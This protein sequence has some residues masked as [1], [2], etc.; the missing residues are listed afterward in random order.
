MTSL[1]TELPDELYW[2]TEKVETLVRPAAFPVKQDSLAQPGDTRYWGQPDWPADKGE[3]IRE[4][5]FFQLNL[6]T[7]PDEAR[8]PEWPVTGLVWVFMD[9]MDE[10]FRPTV[11]F[12]ARP[13]ASIPW[14]PQAAQAGC[15]YIIKDTVPEATPKTLPE[16]ANVALME[17]AYWGWAQAVYAKHPG[18]L[19]VGGWVVPFQGDFDHINST[20][21]C[22]LSPLSFGDDGAITLHYSA[23]QGFHAYAWTH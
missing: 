23:D 20:L 14:L 13:A 19:Q 2:L 9:V 18:N 7:I 22:E 11:Y 6:E 17:E 3:V 5:F 15:S 1:Y 16:I 8:K 21:V 4:P 12:D 10:T